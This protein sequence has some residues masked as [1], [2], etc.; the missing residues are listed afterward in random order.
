MM[1]W[2]ASLTEEQSGPTSGAT[3]S[4]GSNSKAVGMGG[5]C[6]MPPGRAAIRRG[7]SGGAQV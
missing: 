2:A 3:A 5:S 4:S 7:L 1:F 6:S